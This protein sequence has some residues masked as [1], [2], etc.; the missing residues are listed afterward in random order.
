MQIEP[1]AVF[2]SP[3]SGKFGVPRQAGLAGGLRGTIEL[4]GEYRR[5]EALRGLDGFDYLWLIWNFNL[6]YCSRHQEGPAEHK[7]TVVSK[8]ADN[9]FKATVR[10][11]RLGGNERIGVFASRSPFRP[12]GLGL[13]SVKIESI[14]FQ[15]CTI[16]VSGADLA[17]GTPVFDIKPYVAYTDSH[18]DATCGFA[19]Q[20]KEQPPLTIND[21][22][23][24]LSAFTPRQQEALR[25]ILAHDPRPHYQDDP[26]R[27]YALEF[28]QHEIHFQVT[29][30]LLTITAVKL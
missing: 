30:N 19:A 22:E 9:C 1:I 5:P 25:A 4:T 2:H 20:T 6:N 18:P 7:E 15:H 16:E 17:D 11:P 8:S 14:D 28:A 24:L 12:N 21:P 27:T 10:P 26:S 29:D 3:I 23:D 13:S